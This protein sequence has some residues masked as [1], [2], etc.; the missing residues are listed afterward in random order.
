MPD[1]VSHDQLWWV[2]DQIHLGIIGVL[3]NDFLAQLLRGM[4]RRTRL[5]EVAEL[6]GRRTSGR[7]EHLVLVEA[8]IARDA[9]KAKAAML[10][11]LETVRDNVIRQLRSL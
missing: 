2:D 7:Q 5:F 3:H 11:H 4:R 8:L 1:E 10:H 6:P 9:A